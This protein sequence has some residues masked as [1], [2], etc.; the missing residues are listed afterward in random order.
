MKVHEAK[1]HW[2]WGSA[3][4]LAAAPHR[5]PAELGWKYGGIAGF[6]VLHRRFLAVTDP[7]FAAHIFV[8]KHEQ[9]RRSFHYEN[10]QAVFG[11]GMI[12]TDGDLWLKERRRA[13]PA[14]RVD[15]IKRVV[16]A[17]CAATT[18]LLDAWEAK[19]QSNSA[20]P[21]VEDMRRLAMSVIT[22]ALLSAS[23]DERDAARFGEAVADALLLIRERN[24]SV[25]NPPLPVPTRRNRRLRETRQI[26]DRYI[27]AHLTARKDGFTADDILEALVQSRDPDT[28]EG[29]S[30]EALI[31]E[32]KTLFAAGFETTA[33]TLAW[34]L[35]L[36]AR[37]PQAARKWHEEVDRVVG[38]ALPAWEHLE[39]LTWIDQVLLESMRIYPPVYTMA[40]ECLADDVWNGKEIPRGSVLLLSIYGM[41]RAQ[42]YWPDA[43]SFLPERFSPGKQWPKNAFMP[44][45]LG[46]HTCIGASFAMTEMKVILAMIGQR[47]CLS[48]VDTREVRESAR[49]TL[50]PAGEIPIRLEQR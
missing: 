26:L 12:S 31:D 38:N 40:R 8:E 39:K 29:F 17:T 16:P 6:R 21:I 2:L 19:R 5:F 28:G 11:K 4:E 47:F 25:F 41:H 35:C 46:K 7:D 34:T 37:H 45:G 50:T 44:F 3:R 10:Q 9:Y 1:G 20:V 14:F 18:G 24:T 42:A 48:A 13:L 33:S 30:H 36:L 27:E 15:T 43:E 22:R 49:I 23:P 32:T